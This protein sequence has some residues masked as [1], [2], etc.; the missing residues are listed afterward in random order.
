MQF[1]LVVAANDACSVRINLLCI[2]QIVI[3]Q[4]CQNHGWLVKLLFLLL[5]R[6]HR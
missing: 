1:I 3:Q 6:E 2:L 4:A 5:F